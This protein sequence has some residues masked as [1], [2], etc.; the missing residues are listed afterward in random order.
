MIVPWATYTDPALTQYSDYDEFRYPA[1]ILDCPYKAVWRGFEQFPESQIEKFVEQFMNTV[2]LV[3]GS[4]LVPTEIHYLGPHVGCDKVACNLTGSL[5]FIGGDTQ[6]SIDKALLKI[7]NIFDLTASLATFIIPLRLMADSI[8]QQ[9]RTHSNDLGHLIAA[10]ADDATSGLSY[11]WL[12]HL[13]L[14][15]RTYLSDDMHGML[16]TPDKDGRSDPSKGASL[17]LATQ[18]NEHTWE[19]DVTSYSQMRPSESG[20][21]NFGPFDGFQYPD[22]PSSIRRARSQSSQTRTGAKELNTGAPSTYANAVGS[23]GRGRSQARTS[24]PAIRTTSAAASDVSRASRVS[25]TAPSASSTGR[26][27]SV[28]ETLLATNP[29]CRRG[30]NQ[31]LTPHQL[32]ELEK[33]IRTMP[34]QVPEVG[35]LMSFNELDLADPT[36]SPPPKPSGPP[37]STTRIDLSHPPPSVPPTLSSSV[38]QVAPTGQDGS[39][40]QPGEASDSSEDLIDFGVQEHPVKKL[41]E[42]M[43]QRA[44]RRSKA[45][46]QQ[47][48]PLQSQPVQSRSLVPGA[49]SKPHIDLSVSLSSPSPL[50]KTQIL[51]NMKMRVQSLAQNLQI[52]S[53]EVRLELKFGRLY[54][55][56]PSSS[57]IS[58]AASVSSDL[59]WDF[60]AARQE[61]QNIPLGKVGFQPILSS[62]GADANLLVQIHEPGEP[63]WRVPDASAFYRFVCYHAPL[64]ICFNVD[65]DSDCLSHKCRG[66]DE[67]IDHVHIH[68]PEYAWDMKICA[69]RA[70]ID[71][72]EDF[73]KFAAELVNSLGVS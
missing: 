52:I 55:Q 26:P 24:T 73:L 30:Q 14:A 40:D 32:R 38:E 6:E 16:L 48:L 43:K 31:D 56:N 18:K 42:T 58:D 20:G 39:Q 44:G 12:T 4:F 57:T 45:K 1:V 35:D 10:C 9:H 51:N 68:C 63:R 46:N 29:N 28:K 62:K 47:R 64:R 70:R 15:K 66:L 25:S 2:N 27:P 7:D 22:K 61:L 34:S 8:I 41:H 65:I 36:P 53:G 54:I 5:L 69:T 50:I 17:R 11:R 67:D 19:V 33:W 72:P 37:P 23:L 59:V 60:D 3:S 71:F 13:S 49:P 21:G